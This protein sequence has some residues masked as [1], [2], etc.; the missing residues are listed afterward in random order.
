[1]TSEAR[2]ISNITP[3]SFPF[4][5][6][7][8]FQGEYRTSEPF[9]TVGA[10][11]ANA[12]IGGGSGGGGGGAPPELITACV[13]ERWHQGVG[14]TVRLEFGLASSHHSMF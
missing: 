1:M 10:I 12:G 7:Y 11:G 5:P 3:L 8:P 6:I 2:M 14:V 4:Y 13:G 9:P